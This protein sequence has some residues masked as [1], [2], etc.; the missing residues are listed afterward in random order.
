MKLKSILFAW[1]IAMLLLGCQAFGSHTYKGALFD[2]PMPLSDFQLMDAH[3]KPVKLSDFKDDLVLVY[4]GYTFCPDACPLTLLNV[5]DALKDLP[6]REHVHVLFISVDHER[7]TP[8]VMTRY[9]N[10]F[11]SSFIGITDNI[12]ATQTVLTSFGAM[13]QKEEVKG[14]AASYLVSHTTRL[15]LVNGKRELLLTYPFQF[16]T[17][18]L[19]SDLT[20][21]LQN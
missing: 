10:A 2:P 11:D 19:R 3:Q 4:F 17:E 9:V 15:Y 1:L 8:E 21:L 6:D 7:D 12:S 5:R 13:A 20:Y 16:A 18:D 14:S